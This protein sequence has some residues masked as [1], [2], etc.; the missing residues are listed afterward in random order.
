MPEDLRILPKLR[1]SLTFLYIDKAVIEQDAKS[2]AAVRESSRIPI[3][4]AAMTVLFLGSGTSVT[5]AAMKTIAESGCSVVWCGMGAARFYAFGQGETRS[6]DNLLWQAKLHAEPA[7][8]MEVV[9]RMY[10]R[11]FRDMKTDGMTLQQIRGLEGIR[12]REA[13]RNAS[14]NTGVKW[15]K[16]D[17]KTEDWNAADD[18]NKA[19][20]YANVI[21]YAI[22]QAAVIS[23]GYSTG[24]GF[25][26]TGKQL[27]FVYDIADLYKADTTIPAAFAAVAAAPGSDLEK[28]IRIECRRRFTAQKLL[29]RLPEDIAWIFNIEVNEEHSAD[30]LPGGLWEEHGGSVAG[31]KN[32]AGDDEL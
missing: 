13:Y 4:I 1:D 23:L 3:P 29:A 27:S 11:R 32:Y 10:A 19:L 28:Q 6:A 8:H 20:S 15:V 21:L 31:G 17:Y 16:R 5:H 14:K 9:R 25:I 24:L 12:V 22:C 26:H 2:I 7:A 18:I 30:D